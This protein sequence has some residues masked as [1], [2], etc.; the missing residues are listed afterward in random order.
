MV[1]RLSSHQQRGVRL[2][3]PGVIFI[4]NIWLYRLL[5]LAT[6]AANLQQENSFRLKYQFGRRPAGLI[7]RKVFER[8]LLRPARAVLV[9]VDQPSAPPSLR[10]PFQGSP[11]ARSLQYEYG[12]SWVMIIARGA[13]RTDARLGL[14]RID[15]T[16]QIN[17]S[18]RR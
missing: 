5:Q 6:P 3:P 15:K 11:S 4:R 2:V 9:K 10:D 18:F 7:D 16:L 17:A 14:S 1:R 12:N 13:L 8:P